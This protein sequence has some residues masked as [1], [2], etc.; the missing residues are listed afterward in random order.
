MLNTP[1]HIYVPVES[2][3][4]VNIYEH[5]IAGTPIKNAPAED[6]KA[7]IDSRRKN[8]SWAN[9]RHSGIKYWERQVHRIPPRPI[10]HIRIIDRH[11]QIIGTSRF[12]AN[13][14]F[15]H[16]H[17]L[18]FSCRNISLG[19]CFG[20]QLL[21]CIHDL[22]LLINESITQ[23]R[24]PVKVFGHHGKDFGVIAKRKNT[25]TVSYTHL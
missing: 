11:I 25:E 8:N 1:V 23:P 9:N 21:N 16:Y 6:S 3:C 14:T 20:A 12:N 5:H 10:N 17:L 19:V 4:S 7:D 22:L 13:N 24:R 15:L 18:L 2:F